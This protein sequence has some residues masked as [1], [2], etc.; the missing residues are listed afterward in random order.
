M[1]SE[2]ERLPLQEIVVVLG[3]GAERTLETLLSYPR[4]VAVHSPAGYVSPH[5]AR[6][7]GARLTGADAVLFAD[8]AK[9][10]SAKL[11]GALLV[12]AD[13]G[14]DVVLSDRT[15]QEGAFNRRGAESWLRE[16]LNVSLG[17][18]DLRA[19]AIGGVPF[20][21]SRRA[22]DAIGTEALG[23]PARAQAAA[24]VQ[25]LRISVCGTVPGSGEREPASAGSGHI[26]A[27]RDCLSMRDARLGFPDSKRNRQAIGGEAH[28]EDGGR[29]ARL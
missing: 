29:L 6:A 25:G 12:H 15:T 19:D 22:I 14:T 26:E 21:L 23:I 17:R 3:A 2:L 5:A 9:P 4:V 8:G 1:L 24:L 11:L 10:C 18:P 27:W 20:V 13:A 7:A 16:F 28:G